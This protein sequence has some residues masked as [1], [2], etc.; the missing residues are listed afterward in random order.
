[1]SDRGTWLLR[2]THCLL[3]YLVCLILTRRADAYDVQIRLM[4]LLMAFIVISTVYNRFVLRQRGFE[5][6]PKFTF[7]H[8]REIWDVC[9]EFL[10][11]LSPSLG[12]PDEG[13]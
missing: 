6:L 5:Q 1:M 9:S 10:H 8:A 2:R 3:D 12:I 4:I 7:S 13:L 11:T